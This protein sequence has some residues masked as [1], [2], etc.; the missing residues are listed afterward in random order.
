M[1][2]GGLMDLFGLVGHEGV[3]EICAANGVERLLQ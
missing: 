2:T 1:R 3:I